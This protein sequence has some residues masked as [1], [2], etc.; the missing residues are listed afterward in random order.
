MA[1]GEVLWFPCVS[2]TLPG[3][4][5]F[6]PLGRVLFGFLLQVRGAIYLVALE[7]VKEARESQN[8]L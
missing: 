6:S 7:G 8:G 1:V 2:F 3:V 5:R 4:G